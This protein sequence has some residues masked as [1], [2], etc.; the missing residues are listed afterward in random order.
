MASS[1]T[2][3]VLVADVVGSTELFMR[4]GEDA[5]DV[6]RRAVFA[7]FDAAVGEA[8]GT[9]VKTMGDGC[10]ASFG[11]AADAVSA[12][13][14]LQQRAAAL[15]DRAVPGLGLRVGLAVGDVT[16]E[17]DDIFG[18]A[19]VMASRL[20][21]AA[22][23][24]QV[25]ASEMVR[26]LAGTRGGHRY[27]AAG[28]LIL[29][30]LPDPVAACTVH[31]DAP[32]STRSLPA[33]LAQ[34][35]TEV[36]V[37]RERELEVLVDAAKDAASGC[38]R[39]VLLA[40][41]PGVG[42]TRL[43]AA[44]A[45]RA[46]HDGATVLFGRC[47]EDLTLPFQ[48]FI[49]PLRTIWRELPADERGGHIAGHGG[50]LAR[51]VPSL[52]G[53]EPVRADPDLEQ[54]RLF[55]AVDDV[56][57][58][59]AA[60]RPLVLVL[61]DLHWAAP[62]TVAL[63]RHL[64]LGPADVRL[65]LVGTYRDT[66]VDRAH[67]L[68]GLLSDIHRIDGVERL[69]LRGLDRDAVEDLF[70]ALSGDE[71]DDAGRALAAAVEE[72]TS[73]N[74]FFVNQVLRHLVERGALVQEDGRWVVHGGL[75]ELDLPEGV[76]DVVG[77]RLSGLSPAA[78]QAL[79]V[80]ALCGLAFGV[81]VLR[82]VPDAGGP[83][84]VV[85]ALDEAVRARLLLE[86]G[87]G[88]LTFAH[89]IVRDALLRELTTAKAARL[90]RAI[91]E[92]ILEV[93]GASAPPLAELAHHFTEAAI[94]GD[95]ATAARW[96][97]AAAQAADLQADHRGGLELLA[98]ALAV[99]EAVEPVDHAARFEVAVS[100]CECLYL[101]AESDEEVTATASDAARRLG[102]GV[103]LLRVATGR[104]PGGTG[105]LDPGRVTLFDEALELLP[106]DAFPL[107]ALCVAGRIVQRSVQGDNRYLDGV[108]ALLPQLAPLTDEAPQISRLVHA[109]LSFAMLGLPGA[110]RRLEVAER[111]TAI[112]ADAPDPW[113]ARL[114]TRIDLTLFQQVYRAH[115][116]L[117]LGRRAGCEAEVRDA[118]AAA[119]RTGHLSVLGLTE[120]QLGCLDLLEGRFDEAL[121]RSQAMMAASPSDVNFVLTWFAVND[122]VLRE[123]GRLEEAAEALGAVLEVTDLAAARAT[124]A[125]GAHEAGRVEEANA[126]VDQLL[127]GWSSWGRDW[128]WPGTVWAVAEVVA[129]RRDRERV[130]VVLDELDAYAGELLLI[131]V[132]IYCAGAADRFRGM[133]LDVLDRHD[134]AVEALEAGLALERA[135]DAPVLTSRTQLWLARA[136]V[137]RDGDGDRHRARDH[138]EASMATAR[139][140]GQP[141]V[142]AEAEA[143]LVEL[144]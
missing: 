30:G 66:E 124:V 22:G 92:A 104:Y 116:L 97:V 61:D 89:A 113:H 133:L 10:L 47:E 52:D 59:A 141:I 75:D 33:A 67:A 34:S 55:D 14:A 82:S 15:R 7:A 74:P 132:A 13:V 35:P 128:S 37:G 6:A 88:Q 46:H 134:E 117:A 79:T 24:H 3:T 43:A 63:V 51:L 42:K 101:L 18:P 85:D 1:R 19:V 110:A 115:A 111:G 32:T 127:A 5:A 9:L 122:Q 41:E 102:S 121:A 112:A 99:I 100:M 140:T 96:A 68:G 26:L 136:L 2:V 107:R 58:R 62:A 56:L 139:R 77:R 123:Q 95:T 60:D 106:E 70:T 36:V 20:C 105:I 57:R 86:T 29:K 8:N 16:E 50:E 71:L 28:E 84:A 108:E 131:G 80:A 94:L 81:R 93:Y 69:S 38:R 31:V 98:R 126:L 144:G 120:A 83:D 130:A 135:I 125:R 114:G 25:L 103:A 12:G 39:A 119:E 143:L 90:H 65:L 78:N 118:H 138:L 129:Q 4:L 48:P 40:G 137:H 49:D 27:E 54:A 11:A 17:D 87:P 91:G 21:S 76:L 23:E 73:G 53:P 142:L 45:R 72:R 64:L 44:L 109:L